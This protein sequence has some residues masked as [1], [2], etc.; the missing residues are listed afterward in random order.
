[1]ALGYEGA[2]TGLEDIRRYQRD[3]LGRSD[4]DTALIELS[5]VNAPSLSVEDPERESHRA[6]RIATI[7]RRIE[8]NTPKFVVFYGIGYCEEY[9]K[10]GGG[11]F[12][13]D[14][15]R[16]HGTTLCALVRHPAPPSKLPALWWSAK[17]NEMRKRWI[18]NSG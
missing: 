1:M 3:R 7:R 12:D 9:E 6:E 8:E 17:G 10:V 15:Y 14:G 16:W 13:T 5:A 11:P 4:A 2:P 18:S